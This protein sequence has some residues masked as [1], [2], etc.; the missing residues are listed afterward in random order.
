MSP[1][2]P[3]G[4]QRLVPEWYR[5]PVERARRLTLDDMVRATHL[6]VQVRGCGSGRVR[7]RDAHERYPNCRSQTHVQL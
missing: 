5:P 2:L 1:V 7:P 3:I 6:E 4:H